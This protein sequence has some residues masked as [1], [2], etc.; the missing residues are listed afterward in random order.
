MAHDPS[1]YFDIHHTRADSFEK[2]DRADLD[3]NVAS[4]AVL[5]YCLAQAEGR[6]LPWPGP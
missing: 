1:R 6:A 5:L 4:M 2:I 3:R